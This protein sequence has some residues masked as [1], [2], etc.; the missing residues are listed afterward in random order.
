MGVTLV[1]IDRYEG[2]TEDI[3]KKI[4]EAGEE[5]TKKE[6]KVMTD[7]EAES[8]A[9][10]LMFSEF[11]AHLH[12][13]LSKESFKKLI[14]MGYC[15]AAASTKYHGSCPGGL[16]NHSVGVAGNLCDLSIKMQLK[17]ERTESPLIIG[18][19]HDLCKIDQYI[20]NDDGSYS[21]NKE[22]PEGHGSK[23]VEYIEK[24][25]NIKLTD[26]ERACILHHMGAFGDR[27]EQEAYSKAVKEYPNVLWTHTA[28][29]ITSQ[30]EGV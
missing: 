21:W 20:K 6:K 14:D 4:A 13:L 29:M 10:M 28:D 7:E 23:S 16:F 30:I 22:V 2:E 17:W 5:P 25:T 24:F 26:E 27:V 18:L 9:R 15:N 19:F 3:L 8:I 1:T 12:G 11:C